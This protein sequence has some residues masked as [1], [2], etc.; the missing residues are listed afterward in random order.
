MSGTKRIPIARIQAHRITPRAIAIY[1]QMRRIRCTC[2]SQPPG[3][4]SHYN[5]W[6]DLHNELHLELRLPV[7]QWPCIP[8]IT[9]ARPPAAEELEGE[10]RQAA[11]LQR[12]A[13]RARREPGVEQA[14]DR[15]EA[16]VVSDPAG[17]P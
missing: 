9:G 5:R 1:Q 4:C 12:R 16:V 10:L 15:D 3:G 7:W 11:A 2:P 14:V 13:A 6:F 8:S 17:V